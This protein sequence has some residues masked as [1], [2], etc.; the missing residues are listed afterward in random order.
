MRSPLISV[1][2]GMLAVILTTSGCD[3]AS[4]D[5]RDAPLSRSC[6]PVMK[7]RGHF[8]TQFHHA[9]PGLVN[10]GRPLHGVVVPGCNDTGG[11]RCTVRAPDTHARAWTV[12]HVP[13]SIAFLVHS[14]GGRQLFIRGLRQ[15]PRI[16]SEFRR[17]VLH[18]QI[19]TG[20]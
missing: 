3:N 8:Y 11:S 4:C 7:Y 18:P 2:G 17:L 19:E 15:S 5:G 14:R 10:R 9:I 20:S 12:R 1:V 13:P 16:P 6:I